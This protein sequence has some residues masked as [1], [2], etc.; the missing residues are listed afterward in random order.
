VAEKDIYSN[1]LFKRLSQLGFPVDKLM[2]KYQ[3]DPEIFMSRNRNLFD[4]NISDGEQ[5]SHLNTHNNLFYDVGEPYYNNSIDL[6][7]EKIIL[8]M[9][10]ALRRCTSSHS[11]Q[12][13]QLYAF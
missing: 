9:L 2:E 1:S 10:G 6:L 8:D 12:F 13:F 5:F 3:S 7:E 11:Y 4:G